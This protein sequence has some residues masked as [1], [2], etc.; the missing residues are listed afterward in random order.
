M[1]VF[2]FV[3]GFL[4]LLYWTV[5]YGLFAIFALTFGGG[6][7]CWEEIIGVLFGTV[8]VISLWYF[9]L[10]NAPFMLIVSSSL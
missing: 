3:I 9:L 5:V 8:V 2:G 4:L 6:R 10:S 7:P 1:A